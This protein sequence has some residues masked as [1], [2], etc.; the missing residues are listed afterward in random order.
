MSCCIEERYVFYSILV[1]TALGCYP[2]RRRC[3]RI[4][5]TIVPDW[6]V[7]LRSPVLG[8]A[9]ATL[10]TLTPEYLGGLPGLWGTNKPEQAL[11][12]RE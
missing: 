2:M 11:F 12:P 6:G 1:N 5:T 8:E 10:S 4:T 3:V 7:C 9:I